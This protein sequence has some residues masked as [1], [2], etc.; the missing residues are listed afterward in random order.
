MGNVQTRTRTPWIETVKGIGILLVVLG[1]APRH[2]MMADSTLC[3]YLAYFIYSFHMPLYFAISGYTFGLSWQRYRDD[4]GLFLGRRSKSLLVPMLSYGTVVYLVF[5]GAYSIPGI[6]PLLSGS[7]YRKYGIGEYLLLMLVEDNPYCVHLWYLWVLFLM[8]MLCFA[9]LRQGKNGVNSL[10]VFALACFAVT[11]AGGLPEVLHKFGCYLI[12]FVLGIRL[13]QGQLS[14]PRWVRILCWAV[15]LVNA[16]VVRD[17]VLTGIPWAMTVQKAVLL[18]AVAPVIQ[19]L[20]DLAKC[21]SGNRFFSWLGKESFA[22]YLLHQPLCAF[23]GVLLYGKL[24][25]PLWP[26]FLTC[27]MM[28]IL[29]PVLVLRICRSVK[30]LGILAKTL[31]N[32]T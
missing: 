18:M 2:D 22:I 20:F 19:D 4:A 28:S 17:R 16:P 27:A 32:I 26:V 25:L 24:G 3:G 5:V 15:L 10:T 31:L 6:G 12:Y 23:L 13:T 21:L 29:L 30:P 9:W 11:L 14:T 7:G 8:S 1:H